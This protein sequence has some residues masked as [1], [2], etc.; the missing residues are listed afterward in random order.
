MIYSANPLERRLQVSGTLLILGLMTEAVYLFPARPL[1]FLA[2]ITM[3]AHFYSQVRL[4]TCWRFCPPSVLPKALIRSHS[5]AA[6][7]PICPTIWPQRF[8]AFGLDA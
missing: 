2:F 8:G 4:C 1:S 5:S 3:E 6:A 7:V